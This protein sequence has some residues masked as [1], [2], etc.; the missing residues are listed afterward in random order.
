[1]ITAAAFERHCAW[2]TAVLAGAGYLWVWRYVCGA[3][4]AAMIPAEEKELLGGVLSL[5]GA[6]VG[7]LATGQALLCSLQDNAVV[8]ELRRLRFYQRTMV[9]F[10]R[11]IWWALVASVLSLVGLW[12]KFGTHRAWFAVWIGC[13]AGAAVAILRIILIFARVLHQV[14]EHD[15][16]GGGK[17]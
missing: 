3:D 6:A 11:A 4:P 9:F 8:K 7:F 2:L 14:H 1:M 10:T 17:T 12:I 15:G 5:L 13:A 16:P